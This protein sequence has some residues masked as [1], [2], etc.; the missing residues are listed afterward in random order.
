[1][2]GDLLAGEILFFARITPPSSSKDLGS[3]SS[4]TGN[5]VLRYPNVPIRLASVQSDSPVSVARRV[6]SPDFYA[7]VPVYLL[8]FRTG[9]VDHNQ[10]VNRINPHHRLAKTAEGARQE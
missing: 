10:T 5:L 1:M 3:A 6:K 8:L 7:A 4:V 9:A 2:I